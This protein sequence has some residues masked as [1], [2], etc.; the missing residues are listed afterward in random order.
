MKLSLPTRLKLDTILIFAAIAFV[1][2]MLTCW[3]A[4]RVLNETNKK[5]ASELEVEMT[6]LEGSLTNRI[7]HTF[8]IIQNINL[9]IEENPHSKKHIYEILKRYRTHPSLT[10]TFS[11]TI[12]SWSD[13]KYRITVDA[14]YGILKEPDEFYIGNRNYIPLTKETPGEFLLGDPVTGLTSKKWMVPG[15][16]GIVDENGDYLGAISIGFEIETLA[17]LLHKTLQNPYVKFSLFSDREK[18]I[19]QGTSSSYS[20][21]DSSNDKSCS[22]EINYVFE[23][24]ISRRSDKI[25][26][27]SLIKNPH[28]FLVKRISDY[29]YI[30]FLKYDVKE[31]SNRLWKNI[32]SESREVLSIAFGFIILL[33]L[34]YREK[35]NSQRIDKLTNETTRANEAKTEFLI[36]SAQEFKSFIFGIQGCAEIIKNDLRRLI[37][38]L[39]KYR[40]SENDIDFNELETDLD[41]TS[42]IIEMSHELNDFIA[43]L[44]DLNHAENGYFKIR[45]IHKA[46]NLGRIVKQAIKLLRKRAE[47]SDIILVSKIE[48][49]LFEPSDLDPERIKQ[50]IISLITN[51]IQYSPKNS[52]VEIFVKNLVQ[53]DTPTKRIEIII[54]DQGFGMNENELKF[55]LKRYKTIERLENKKLPSINIGLPLVKYLTEKQGGTFEI[56]SEKGKGTTVRV[57][58]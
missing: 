12:F 50:I 13:E 55:A 24:V 14:N 42:D 21:H 48:D 36:Q 53:Q 19:L 41:L 4:I 29:P 31:I 56:T 30:L 35:K 47:N 27:I 11:W 58:F 46:I 57:I 25:M 40:T 15:G 7:S 33:I 49:N 3:F 9:Q 37:P 5:I 32:V 18:L 23:E 8:S 20:I 6:R 51:S 2:I 22:A 10:D 28:A 26:Q 43:D 45:K 17:K 16:V 54:K 44:I 39:K 52:V 34:I 38:K 1:T